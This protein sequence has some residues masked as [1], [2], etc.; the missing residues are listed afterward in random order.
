MFL[1]L[2]NHS[3]LLIILRAMTYKYLYTFRIT[4]AISVFFRE[5]TLPSLFYNFLPA[6]DAFSVD[7]ICFSCAFVSA[8]SFSLHLINSIE[9]ARKIFSS[10]LGILSFELITVHWPFNIIKLLSFLVTNF[11]TGSVTVLHSIFLHLIYYVSR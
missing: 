10:S 8:R 1:Q 3:G 5:P 2:S 11:S 9:L 4:E 6:S 7:F